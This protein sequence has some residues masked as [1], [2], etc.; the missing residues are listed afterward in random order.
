MSKLA[1][2]GTNTCPVALVLV[3]PTCF[4]GV[5]RFSDPYFFLK[6]LW[7]PLH[8]DSD[9]LNYQIVTGVRIQ[10]VQIRISLII[11]G[12]NFAKSLEFRI[13]IH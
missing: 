3:Y 7:I 10:K 12:L 8:R 11:T 2:L 5:L 6:F 13:R 9:S 4:R 1:K